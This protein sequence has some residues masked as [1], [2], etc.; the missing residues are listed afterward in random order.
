[1][2]KDYRFCE[3]KPIASNKTAKGKQKTE[4]LKLIKE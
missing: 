2:L 1:M 4:E 3:T